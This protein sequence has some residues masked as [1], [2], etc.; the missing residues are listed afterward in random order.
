MRKTVFPIL[1]YARKILFLWSCISALIIFSRIF[2]WSMTPFLHVHIIY[3]RIF[4]RPITQFFTFLRFI[5]HWIFDVLFTDL[6]WGKTPGEEQRSF[7]CR[8][9][10]WPTRIFQT[11]SR[12]CYYFSGQNLSG[13]KYLKN[14]STNVSESWTS[15]GNLCSWSSAWL[16]STPIATNE[17]E[18]FYLAFMI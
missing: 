12:W 16:F 14:L 8:G 7:Y 17:S 10:F 11:V 5:T 3:P 6:F 15:T 4:H 13:S 18:S 2:Q 1:I 9:W